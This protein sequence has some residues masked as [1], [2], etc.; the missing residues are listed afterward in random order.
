[1]HR[2]VPR[3]VLVG[4]ANVVMG[5][6]GALILAGSVPDE[7]KIPLAIVFSTGSGI[8]PAAAYSGAA[9]HAPKADLVA[10]ANGFMVQGA[11]IGMLIGPPLLAVVVGGLGSWE[12]AWWCMLVCPAGGLAI[13]S[14]LFRV[15]RQRP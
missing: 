5:V 12:A 6:T 4:A 2:R 15:E 8:L 9:V 3:Y 11:A 7:A 10:M 14:G 1:M 13:T